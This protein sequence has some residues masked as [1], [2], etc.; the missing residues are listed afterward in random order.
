MKL[1]HIDLIENCVRQDAREVKTK[2][3]KT[4]TTFFF[5]VGEESREI[6]AEWVRYLREVK[7]WGND[8]PLFPAE[9]GDKKYRKEV[10]LT[11][12]YAR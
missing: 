5:P 10:L 9:R 7:L 11:A 4:F 6:V 8:D 1:K 2:F 3:S 12:S